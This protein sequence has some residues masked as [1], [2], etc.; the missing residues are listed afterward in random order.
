LRETCQSGLHVMPLPVMIGVQGQILNQKGPW[1]Y[2]AH[3]TDQHVPQAWYLIQAGL[4]K[5]SPEVPQP[6]T[7]AHG[8]ITIAEIHGAELNEPKWRAVKARPHLQKKGWTPQADQYSQPDEKEHWR[9]NNQKN[10][11]HDWVH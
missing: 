11:C 6:V 1:P 7:I 5:N 8:L 9:E 2:K 3:I 10:G 4:A